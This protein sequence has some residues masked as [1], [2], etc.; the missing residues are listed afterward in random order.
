MLG[1]RYL[2]RVRQMLDEIEQTQLGNIEQASGMIADSLAGG[3]A[4]PVVSPF[5]LD[6]GADGA[7]AGRQA[8]RRHRPHSGNRLFAV[9]GVQGL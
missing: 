6:V 4:L 7:G 5:P 8:N 1:K 2:D 3:G 9:P